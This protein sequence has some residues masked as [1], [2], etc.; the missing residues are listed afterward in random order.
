MTT[1]GLYLRDLSH[2]RTQSHGIVNYALGLC[3]AIGRQLAATERLVVFANDEIVDEITPR[4]RVEIL[5]GGPP[6][7]GAQQLLSDHL[8][9]LQAARRRGLAVL[10]FPKGFIPLVNPTAVRLA[11]TIHDDIPVR[12]Q[13]GAWGA[14]HRTARTRYFAWSLGHAAR[15]ADAVLTVSEFT[16]DQLAA[17]WPGIRPV[18]TGQG[19]ALPAVD[20]VPLAS[21]EP[22]A[23]HFGSVLPHKRSEEALVAM[24][25]WIEAHPAGAISQV[26]VVGS[27]H[28]PRWAA[29][30]LVRVLPP[31]Q[32]NSA[33]AALLARAR[34][35]LFTSE[36]EGF[37]LPPLEASLLATPVVYARIPAVAEVL[38]PD[39]AGG[40]ERGD[41]ASFAAAVEQALSHDDAALRAAADD[42]A[43]RHRWD[44][45]A[46]AT[47]AV[48]RR[49]RPTG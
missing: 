29:H 18:V 14:E 28:D 47:L 10:H 44:D 24:T 8:G 37:G 4:E 2:A 16:R 32:S 9:S 5:T 21:R 45:V 38:G 33:V 41:R 25:D 27:L 30:P 12:Y 48:Y 22:Y 31:G 3:D 49:C 46:A 23:V 6:P 42:A 34:L 40:Y 26:R 43:A 39:A 35:L 15:A 17:R 11:A 7:R 13:E 36:Y 1:F 19:V 20:F